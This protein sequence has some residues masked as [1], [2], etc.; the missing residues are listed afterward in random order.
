MTVDI[1]HPYTEPQQRISTEL[2]GGGAAQDLFPRVEALLP[3][4]AWAAIM[5]RYNEIRASSGNPAG[6]Y[7]GCAVSAHSASNP[8]LK[9]VTANSVK[10]GSPPTGRSVSSAGATTSSE[11]GEPL[12]PVAQIDVRAAR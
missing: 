9:A 1:A 5:L 12:T 2:G 3:A 8:Y 4:D 11:C 6:H 10:V 7:G